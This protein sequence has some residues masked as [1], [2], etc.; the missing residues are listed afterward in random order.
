MESD[1][2]NLETILIRATVVSLA[3]QNLLGCLKARG[4]L[5][6]AD[7]VIMRDQAMEVAEDM[8]ELGASDLQVRGRRLEAEIEVWWDAVHS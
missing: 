1:K 7:F 5:S 8:Q 6:V 2:V 4:I 3:V